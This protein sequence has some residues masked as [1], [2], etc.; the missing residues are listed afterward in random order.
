MQKNVTGQKWIV[1]AFDE[2]DNTAKT[3][4]AAQITAEISADGAAGGGNITDTNPTELEDGYYVFDITQGESNADLLLILP[5]SSTGNIQVIGV[6]GSV[7]TTEAN[8]NKAS[9]DTNGRIDVIKIAG[10]T[11][12]ANDNGAD[13]NTLITETAK[14]PKS[15]STVTWNATALAS[16][17]AEAVDALESFNL[18]KLMGVAT[19]VAADANLDAIV[20]DGSVLSHIM[21]GNALTD[22]Y[23]ASTDSL[24]AA[25]DHVGDGSNLTEAGGDGDHLTEAGGTGDHLIAINLPNQTMEIIGNITGNLSGSVG[26]VT[27]GATEAK[28]DIIDTVVDAIKVVTDDFADSATTLVSGTVSHDNTP[29]TTTVFFSD[30]VTEA[31]ADHYNGRIVIFTSGALQNQATDITDYE[32]SAGEG[33]FTVTALTEAPGDNIT[34]VIV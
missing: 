14:V 6:P 15:D 12:T 4:D 3:G 5:E 24:Q 10:T 33:K 28:Q 8:R 21:A 32:L 18:D 16:I 22:T 30:D 29:A 9:V 25:R 19:G 7:Y 11:Q 13:I 20:V 2:T 31:T 26:S 17:E 34:F 23:N 27:G 1:F